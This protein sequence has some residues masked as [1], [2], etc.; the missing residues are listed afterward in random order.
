VESEKGKQTA[1]GLLAMLER[2][3]ISLD[4]QNQ[5]AVQSILTGA[6]G[7]LSGTALDA[8]QDHTGD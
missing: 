1:I 5:S 2:S 8:L 7:G 4:E 6:W 3:A